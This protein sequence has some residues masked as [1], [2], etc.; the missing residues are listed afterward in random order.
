MD[1]VKYTK[2][3]SNT[4]QHYTINKLLLYIASYWLWLVI[5]VSLEEFIIMLAMSR[6]CMEETIEL[7]H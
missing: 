3:L 7:T 5:R 2:L 6:Y 1:F 4:N